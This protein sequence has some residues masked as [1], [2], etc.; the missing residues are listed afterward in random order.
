MERTSKRI[1][2]A[3]IARPERPEAAEFEFK[4]EDS[5]GYMLRDTYRAFARELGSRLAHEKV[6]MGMWFFLRALWEEEGLTQRELSRRIG[7]MEPTTVS[8]LASMERRGLV[9]RERD[10]NDRRRR[11][12]RLT[13]KGRNLK[14]KLLPAAYATNQLALEGV[15]ETEIRQ[16]KKA[17]SK[18][19][20]NLIAHWSD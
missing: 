5:V 4:P 19:K 12:V 13:R 6:S 17:L 16:L 8:A 3:G 1:A 7:M 15:S 11:I 20:Q 10:P 9:K 14:G 2:A 18:M